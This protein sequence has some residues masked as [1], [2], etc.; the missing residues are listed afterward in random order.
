MKR[1]FLRKLSAGTAIAVGLS[2]APC[3]GQSLPVVAGC[4]AA[5]FVTGESNSRIV[6][7]GATYNPKCLRVKAGSSVTIQASLHHPLAAM[8]NIDGATNPFSDR[9]SFASAQTRVLDTPGLFGY[10]CEAHGDAEGDGMAGV[11]LVE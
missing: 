7:S 5:D 10:F 3:L 6:T 1:N 2:S 4:T 11:I 9:A 8:P